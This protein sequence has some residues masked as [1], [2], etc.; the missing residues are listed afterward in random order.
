[1]RRSYGFASLIFSL[2]AASAGCPGAA[3]GPGAGATSPGD[4]APAVS[5]PDPTTV[6]VADWS[7]RSATAPLW[8]ATAKR[9]QIVITGP[10]QGEHLVWVVLEGS[11]LFQVYRAD[12][13]ASAS[14]AEI[15][16]A[17]NQLAVRDGTV[18]APTGAGSGRAQETGVAVLIAL[19]DGSQGTPIGLPPPGKGPRGVPGE[20]LAVVMK[21]V[22]QLSVGFQ[23][24][25]AATAEQK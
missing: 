20:A 5:L 22:A 21:T 9:V 2:A 17:I 25:A 11:S 1:M 8:P 24:P 15:T 12:A 18:T 4:P 19:G 3:A 13:S 23:A 10:L 7:A 16:A 14:P 6:P